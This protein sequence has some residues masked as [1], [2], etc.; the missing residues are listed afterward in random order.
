MDMFDYYKKAFKNYA[1]YKGRATQA[2][3]WYFVLCHFLISVSL[4]ILII[5]GASGDNE[6]MAVS[7]GISLGLYMLAAFIPTL[8]ISIRRL[9][10]TGKSG[11]F[12]MFGFI[13]AIGGILLTIFLAQKS[14]GDNEW[15]EKLD[16]ED[17]PIER[18]RLALP[19]IE[20]DDD[21]V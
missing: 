3:F 11:W 16:L 13:P 15:G 18:E 12:T 8:M 14:D 17:L 9:H 7:A 4:L 5:V 20:Y 19:V 2:E 10:D 21:Y 6:L 1:E